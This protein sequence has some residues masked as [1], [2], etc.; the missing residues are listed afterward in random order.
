MQIITF[1]NITMMVA[2]N[3]C[4]ETAVSNAKLTFKSIVET[5]HRS[6]RK[7]VWICLGGIYGGIIKIPLEHLKFLANLPYVDGCWPITPWNGKNAVPIIF[8]FLLPYKLETQSRVHQTQTNL[9]FHW[10]MPTQ[11]LQLLSLA[12]FNQSQGF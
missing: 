9:P 1:L 3:L 2:F 10:K 4:C 12:Q 7:I 6:C 11:I 5:Y 8:S